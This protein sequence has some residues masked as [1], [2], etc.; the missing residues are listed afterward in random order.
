MEKTRTKRGNIKERFL[1]MNVGD[2]IY[3]P[4]DEYNPNTIR[5]TATTTLYKE[6][7]EGMKWITKTDTFGK[8]VAVTRVL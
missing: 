7:A 6:V 1:R 4:F 2:T 5:S 8:R 3:F